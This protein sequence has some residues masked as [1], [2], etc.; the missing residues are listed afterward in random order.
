MV[1][2]TASCL[3]LYLLILR[4]YVHML[5]TCWS[6][7]SFPHRV[8]S[9]DFSFPHRWRFALRGKVSLTAFWANLKMCPGSWEIASTHVA[10]ELSSNWHNICPCTWR[11]LLCSH[12]TSSCYFCTVF[13]TLVLMVFLDAP[14]SFFMASTTFEKGWNVSLC[15]LRTFRV[16]VLVRCRT[17]ESFHVIRVVA[18]EICYFLYIVAID[19]SSRPP[20]HFGRYSELGSA[21]LVR[22]AH[23]FKYLVAVAVSSLSS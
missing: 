16:R 6:V 5:R 12:I 11:F 3:W 4:A 18:F 19:G 8:H 21:G 20:L 7:R 10:A 23:F 1:L 9:L 2:S 14:G 15:L 13:F 17:A 22:L